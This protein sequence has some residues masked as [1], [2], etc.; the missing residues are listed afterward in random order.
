MIIMMEGW[1]QPQAINVQ[2]RRGIQFNI[3]I[4][5]TLGA[6]AFPSPSSSSLE[7]LISLSAF[8]LG[9]AGTPYKTYFFSSVPFMGKPRGSGSMVSQRK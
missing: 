9:A 1:T 8:P 4:L 7:A 2:V 6:F 5:V 3:Q